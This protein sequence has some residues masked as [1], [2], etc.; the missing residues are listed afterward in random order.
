LLVNT[1]LGFYFGPSRI[2]FSLGHVLGFRGN[3]ALEVILAKKGNWAKWAKSSVSTLEK[4]R[5]FSNLLSKD[6]S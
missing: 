2:G 1:R 5:S 6:E 4:P 3:W